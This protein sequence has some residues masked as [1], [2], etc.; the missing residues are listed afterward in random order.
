MRRI[1]LSIIYYVYKTAFRFKT[2]TL[3]LVYIIVHYSLFI[4]NC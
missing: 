2:E 4:V 3:F 1:A